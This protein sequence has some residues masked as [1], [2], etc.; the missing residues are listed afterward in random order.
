MIQQRTSACK[1][2]ANMGELLTNYSHSKHKELAHFHFLFSTFLPKKTVAPPSMALVIYTLS[3]S[4][5]MSSSSN[6]TTFS[7]SSTSPLSCFWYANWYMKWYNLSINAYRDLHLYVV[8]IVYLQIWQNILFGNNKYF[9]KIG[10]I[11]GV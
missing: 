7:M 6:T 4:P 5:I 3:Y 9:Y 10:H 1:L 2:L 11:H 8:C